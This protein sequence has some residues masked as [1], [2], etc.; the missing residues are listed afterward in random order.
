MSALATFD[1]L[2]VLSRAAWSDDDDERAA[3]LLGVASTVVRDYCGWQISAVTDQ[4]VMLDGPGGHLL[5]LPCM[6]VSA[7]SAV[8]VMIGDGLVA[9]VDYIPS[10]SSGMLRRRRGWPSEFSSIEVTYSGGYDPVPDV[11]VAVVC[12][13]A[14]RAQTLPVGVSQEAT[15]LISRTY[16]GT[17]TGPVSLNKAERDVLGPYR[18]SRE[19]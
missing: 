18:M 7:V 17:D 6:N 4:T 3:A 8:Q 15:G 11:V 13:I 10:V 2:R 14:D 12:A 5:S 19:S 1:D 16:T 9:V